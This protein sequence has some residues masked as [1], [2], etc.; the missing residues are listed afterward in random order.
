MIYPF[1]STDL[2]ESLPVGL[3]LFE[4]ATYSLRSNVPT[5]CLIFNG[6]IVSKD[7]ENWS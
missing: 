7:R 1:H 2:T 3:R 6:F 5:A 4:S